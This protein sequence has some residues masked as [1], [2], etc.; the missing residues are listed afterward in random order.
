MCRLA[1]VGFYHQVLI[2]KIGW[3]SIIGINA[4]DFYRSQ[5]QL[6]YPLIAKISLYRLLV[7]QI[8]FSMAFEHQ[9]GIG[10]VL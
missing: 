6:I 7:S 4:T 3:K 10:L 5:I 2:N 8:Q 9:L 1:Q